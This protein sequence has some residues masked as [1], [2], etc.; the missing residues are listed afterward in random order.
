MFPPP[1]SSAESIKEKFETICKK[2]FPGSASEDSL[3]LFPL[4]SKLFHY[5][6]CT[7]N[8]LMD[9]IAGCKNTR[10]RKINFEFRGF[11]NFAK[12]VSGQ[13]SLHSFDKKSWLNDETFWLARQ[14]DNTVC[15]HEDD[16]LF[17][18]TSLKSVAKKCQKT[19]GSSATTPFQQKSLCLCRRRRH[20]FCLCICVLLWL[21]IAISSS[22]FRICMVIQTWSSFK[23]WRTYPAS[24][25]PL[26]MGRVKA[27]LHLNGHYNI[28]LPL[29][30]RNG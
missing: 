5:F 3:L 27:N 7:I 23:W 21:W 17:S 28:I 1:K 2:Y 15:Q 18:L 9:R 30:C 29:V 14:K 6:L 25:F 8:L 20:C 22:V 19:S 12:S 11:L 13:I 16:Y 24:P 4:S 26:R 10:R